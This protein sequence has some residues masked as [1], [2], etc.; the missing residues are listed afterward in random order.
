MTKN[1]I[2]HDLFSYNR[3][4]SVFYY[5][6]ICE[7]FYRHRLPATWNRIRRQVKQIT[8]DICF[9]TQCSWAIIHHFSKIPTKY[10][11]KNLNLEQLFFFFSLILKEF[12]LIYTIFKFWKVK[13]KKILLSSVARK[14]ILHNTYIVTS[15]RF[16]GLKE[17][18][19]EHYR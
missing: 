5:A 19:Q 9:K 1:S 15:Q 17:L 3:D 8:G 4:N 13:K 10:K 11:R 14:D 7:S 16:R 18:A 6:K 2:L 12:S